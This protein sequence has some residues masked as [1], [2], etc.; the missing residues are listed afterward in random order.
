M[1]SSY[2]LAGAS[3]GTNIYF[4]ELQ[5]KFDGNVTLY[6]YSIRTKKKRK[7]GKIKRA[8]HIVG[9]YGKYVY[10]NTADSE[11]HSTGHI[12]RYNVKTKKK[13]IYLRNYWLGLANGRYLYLE[14][15]SNFAHYRYDLKKKKLIKYNWE[16]K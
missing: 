6:K 1:N 11:G 4:T 13:S 5:E 14:K 16:Y 3:N 10:G 7:I 8:L 12:Y 9:V 15:R 2:T